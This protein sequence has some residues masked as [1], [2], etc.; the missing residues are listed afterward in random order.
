VHQLRLGRRSVPGARARVPAYGRFPLRTVPT[1]G[2]SR[3]PS[4][5]CSRSA[6][7][8]RS[9]T[10]AQ[11]TPA[12]TTPRGTHGVLTA[13]FRGTHRVLAAYSRAL[14]RGT[15]GVLHGYSVGTH[16]VLRGTHSW[17][18]GQVHRRAQRRQPLRVPVQGG[19]LRRAQTAG[20]GRYSQGYSQGTQAAGRD[21][22]L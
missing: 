7:A 19:V 3:L 4:A 22:R 15:R 18:S 13:Y 21:G 16:G 5:I 17:L 2:R 11:R 12:G 14:H 6:R 1:C 20:R 10:R 9:A 8:R